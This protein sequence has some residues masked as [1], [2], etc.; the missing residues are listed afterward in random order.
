M[1]FLWHNADEV[2]DA[3]INE[4]MDVIVS[5][6]GVAF[7]PVDCGRENAMVNFT[8]CLE[9]TG[10]KTLALDAPRQSNIANFIRQY[11]S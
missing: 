4:V 6:S 2:T 5:D 1:N 10:K 11:A 8:G 3:I 7:I 9:G